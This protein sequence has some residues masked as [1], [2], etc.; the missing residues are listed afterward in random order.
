M[1]VVSIFENKKPELMGMG[2]TTHDVTGY[3]VT[4]SI[5]V[6]SLIII[7]CHVVLSRSARKVKGS[8]RRVQSGR[9]SL[10]HHVFTSLR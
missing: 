6:A 7:R 5:E 3:G 1:V 2:A 9:A 4:V 10:S 8:R